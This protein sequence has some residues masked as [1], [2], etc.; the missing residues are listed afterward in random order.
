MLTHDGV[1]KIMDLGL[2]KVSEGLDAMGVTWAGQAVGTPLYMPPEQ[3]AGSDKIDDRADVYALGATLYHL[4][5]GRPPFEGSDIEHL[6][7]LH[8]TAP[9]TWTDEELNQFPRWLR[10]T[11]ESCLAKRREHRPDSATVVEQALRANVEPVRRPVSRECAPLPGVV[12]TPFQNLSRQPGDAWIGDAIAECLSSRLMAFEGVHVADRDVFNT[13]VEQQRQSAKAGESDG[14][15]TNMLQAARLVGV[16]HV[17]MG[18]FHR[19][20]DE[21]RIIAHVMER[22]H[23]ETRFL[24]SVQG[25]AAGLF[26]LEDELTDKIV[27]AMGPVLNRARRRPPAGGGTESLEAHEKYIRGKQSFVEGDYQAA[28]N[29]AREAQA[30]DPQYAEPLSLMGSAYARLGEYERA[31]DCHERQER[32]ARD[33]DDRWELAVALGNLGAMYYYKGEYAIAYEFLERATAMRDEE[34]PAA[35]TA[36]L[37]GNLGMV[38]M[39]L[40]RTAEAEKAFERAIA[41]CKQLNDLASMVW[42]YNG[43]GSVLL[44]QDRTAEAREFHQRALALAEEI[45]DRV[46]VGVSQMNLGRC[47]CLAADFGEAERWFRESLATLD[48]TRFW[49]GLTLVYEHMAEMYLRQNRAEDA[50]ATVEQRIGLARRHGN[51]RMEAQAWEQQARAFELIGRTDDALKALKKSVE[52]SQQPA[53]YESLHRYLEEVTSRSAFR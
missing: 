8:R 30:I 12:V 50:L 3:F 14:E 13:I 7:R 34:S 22:E 35:D 25:P 42:P 2:V 39:R 11:V 44:K 17:F 23:G 26:A 53:P 10:E 1:A 31:V 4:L 20:G 33:H 15:R 29:L 36:K 49:N 37:F 5:T 43:M 18:S 9:V 45:G 46:M 21:V 51:R 16:S 6:A 24:G 41:Q 47:A 19:Q 27:E 32:L 38:L 40:D 28:I 48:R 52:I